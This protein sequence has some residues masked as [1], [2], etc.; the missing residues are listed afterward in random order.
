MYSQEDNRKQVS[1][2]ALF[3][4]EEVTPPTKSNEW[5]TPSRYIEA[6]RR[7]MGSIDLD[8]ASCEMANKVVKAEK[9]YNIKDNGLLQSWHGNIWLNPPYSQAIR[10]RGGL[11]TSTVQNFTTKLL[12]EFSI[13]NIKQAILLATA[14]VNSLWFAPMWQYTICF[15]NHT[16]A[17]YG[18]KTKPKNTLKHLWGSCFVYLGPS[19]SAFIEH[20]SPFGRIAK[21]IDVPKQPVHSP[22]LWE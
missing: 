20:F 5:Y 1:M 17:F 4:Q 12:C 22:T 11:F 15:P 13:G 18:K 14:Q 16:I 9:F 7:V 6:A 2:L 21:A 3:E 8:P 19:E 10:A